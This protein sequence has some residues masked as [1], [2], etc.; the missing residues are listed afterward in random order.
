MR[1]RTQLIASAILAGVVTLLVGFGL[2][3]VT[4]QARSGLDE[5]AEAQQVARDVA[6]MLSLTNE[7][8]LFGGERAAS[9][10]RVRHAQLLAA[11]D[12]AMLR[13]TPPEPELVELRNNLDDLPA[14]F[15]KLAVLVHETPTPL[16]QRRRDLLLERLLAETQEVVESRHRWATA[17]AQSQERNQR[18]YTVMVL[19]APAIL[20]LLLFSLGMLVVRR[21]LAPL[22]RLRDAATAM[23]SGDLTVRCAS[24]ARD[25]LGDTARAVDS[26]ALALHQQSAALTSSEQT[27]R[28]VAD[29]IPALIAYVNR[30]EIYEFTN[31]R[32][33]RLFG[34]RPEGY[35]GLTM[36]QVLGAGARL[37]LAPRI[38][39]A[40]RGE[41]QEF[42][43]AGMGLEPQATYSINYVPQIDDDGSVA[44]FYVM[45]MDITAR[46]EAEVRLA[47][48]Q[49]LL[50]EI[51]NNV[52][53]LVAYVD[54]DQRYRFANSKY[55][56][57]LGAD[58][59]AMIGRHVG[60]AVSPEF[61][62]VVKQK[63][64]LALAGQR[65]R[66]QRQSRRDGEDVTYL[67]DFIPDVD[68]DGTVRGF[69]ALTID[70]TERRQAEMAVMRSEQR[71]L[72]LT[73]SIPAMVAYFDM[74]ERCQYANDAAIRS[75]GLQRS[76]VTGIALRT[77]LGEANY[78]QHEPYVRQALAG[79]RARLE[80]HVP[81]Q[82]RVAHF[83][84]HLIPDRV[85]GGE[86]RGF[87]LMTFDITALK[88][89]QQQQAVVERKLRDITDNL[90]VLITY[91]DPEERYTFVNA[92]SRPWLGVEPAAL[93]G[94]TMAESMPRENYEQRRGHV[95][96]ALRG[97][98]VEFSVESSAIGMTRNLQTVYIPD[99]QPDGRV[100]G[101][102]TLSTDVTAL[103]LIERQ[104]SQL[105]RVDTLTGLPNR[106]QFD[107]KLIEGLARS[108]R[109]RCP[110]AVMFLDIDYFKAINDSLGHASGDA[111]L[112]EFGA[113]LKAAVRSTDT[114][115]RLA[116][117]EFV[118][119][120]EGVA[121]EHEAELVA[122][123]IV[124]AVRRPFI[125]DGAEL[126]VTTS[127]GV[128]FAPGETD[129]REL[130]ARADEALYEAKAR[131]RDRFRISCLD[132]VF[133]EYGALASIPD[134]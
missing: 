102:Y 41:R 108:T 86:Q 37:A 25:E 123:K 31:A 55:R 76:S 51:T 131:G 62:D 10:W 106:R 79:R 110:I 89:S 83:Q 105:A 6:N 133:T 94:L 39:A 19:A 73:N 30:A 44:G 4:T 24:T 101:V 11:V 20:L 9:Q 26:M 18:R 66:W 130:L 127:L 47:A 104:L 128:A 109:N 92:T 134:H 99:I 78:A 7:F 80:G 14:L 17:I 21:I 124:S 2:S 122:D 42:E 119:L 107:E 116:G 98:R 36:A 75:Q 82:N 72:E 16:M 33:Q 125:V 22:A 111:V 43:R 77:A 57:W 129:S 61:Y 27:L 13:R 34:F 32:Y 45:A 49:R 90:P 38:E 97:E 67:A 115:A 23:Q 48:S 132:A 70:I 120:L 121:T 91:V 58:H 40:L 3:Y 56:E 81:F 84:A 28:T 54:R 63:G 96:A 68:T 35:V 12:H 8:S 46:K 103:K 74:Q 114:A 88:E 65:V 112:K 52:P 126:K 69:Y 93:V 118:V 87:Y 29:G 53:A 85:D 59:E 50:T 1:I 113:R 117:D 15:E 100:A 5:Q 95:Q 71:L 64:D 60:E